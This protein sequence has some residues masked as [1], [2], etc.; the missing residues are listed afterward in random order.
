V[1]VELGWSNENWNSMAS[2]LRTHGK[3]SARPRWVVLVGKSWGIGVYADS[4]KRVQDVESR[5]D[6]Y[7]GAQ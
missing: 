2:L 3:Q 4:F 5:K 1:S 6:V 7:W